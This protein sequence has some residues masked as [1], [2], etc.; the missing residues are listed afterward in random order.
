MRTLRLPAS[1]DEITP[2]LLADM[3]ANLR[4]VCNL[5]GTGCTVNELPHGISI[6]VPP[7]PLLRQI[8]FYNTSGDTLP[9]YGVFVANTTIHNADG[10]RNVF[11]GDQADSPGGGG[12]ILLIN[13]S[14]DIPADNYGLAWDAKLVPVWA[15]YDT[16]NAPT[17]GQVCGVE[18]GA[19]TLGANLPGFLCLDLDT[20]NNRALVLRVEGDI[21]CQ[22]VPAGSS[23]A[24]TD[25]LNAGGTCLVQVCP[26]TGSAYGAPVGPTLTATDADGQHWALCGEKIRCRPHGSILEVCESGAALR[27]GTYHSNGTVTLTL[28]GATTVVTVYLPSGAS[29]NDATG[30]TMGYVLGLGWQV[31]V[32]PCSSS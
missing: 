23:P 22:V 8:I 13:R 18:S 1:R 29:V 17:A 26:W 25:N 11:N 16:S 9:A 15:I 5:S 20:T 32:A 6:N 3:I 4:K 19:W 2:E 21:V 31:M 10:G 14:T 12:Q 24:T 7:P 27:N 30:V 28:A